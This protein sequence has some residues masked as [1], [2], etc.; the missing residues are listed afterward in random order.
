M[1]NNAERIQQDGPI[2]NYNPAFGQVPSGRHSA[3]R[4][5]IGESRRRRRH[6]GIYTLL[7]K[8]R[9]DAQPPPVPRAV[10]PRAAVRD[11]AGE[12]GLSRNGHRRRSY[13]LRRGLR[14]GLWLRFG[15]WL[16]LGPRVY[17]VRL[18]RGPR[19]GS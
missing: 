3:R 14:L 1:P 8:L 11:Q 13:G 12:I 9:P 16:G 15:L 17:Q 2:A 5:D 19:S 6:H 7:V 10:G 4:G 18:P